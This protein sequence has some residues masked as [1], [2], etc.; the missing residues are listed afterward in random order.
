MIPNSLV[1]SETCDEKQKKIKCTLIYGTVYFTRTL[2]K[3]ADRVD[4]M[5]DCTFYADRSS[6]S[7]C[8]TDYLILTYKVS[9]KTQSSGFNS[10]PNKP[11]FLRVCSTSLLKTLRE[12]EKLPVR[13]NFSFSHNVFY[14]FGQLFHQIVCRLFQFGRV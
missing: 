3:I 10:F 6:S 8:T 1:F 4:R 9:Q 11:W 12:K 14:P 13:S 5:S 7:L 2:L